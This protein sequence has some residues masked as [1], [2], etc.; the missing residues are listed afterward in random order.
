MRR[1]ALGAASALLC[2]SLQAQQPFEAIRVGG[3]TFS[4]SVRDRVENWEWFTPAGT[5]NPKYTFNGTT[6]RFGL[7][8][9]TKTLDW[10]A[11]FEAPILLS[12]P[13]NAVATGTPGQLGVGA[14]YYV[15]NGRSSNSAMLFPDKLFVRLHRFLGSEAG[16]L[17]VGRFDFQDGGEVAPKDATLAALKR[18][19]IQQRLI[20]PFSFTDVMRA[21]DGFHYVYNKP[22]VN[23]TLIGAVPTRGVFQTDGWGWLHVAFGYGSV[24]GQMHHG[25]N[26][27]DWRLFTIYYQDWRPVTKTDNRAAAAKAA[28]HAN[29]RIETFGGHFGNVTKTAAGSLDVMGEIAGQTG[30]WGVETQRAY[31]FDAEAG[32]QPNLLP[33]LKPW[34]RA[35]YYYG[36]GDSNANDNRHGTFFQLLPTA[37]PYARMPFFDMENLADRF[38]MLTLKPHKRVTFHNEIHSLRLANRNDLWYTG[39]G[40]YQPWTFGYTGRSAGGAAS[41]ANLFDVNVDV[42]VN[43]HLSVTPYLGY[44]AGKSVI[45]AVYPKGKDGHLAFLEATYRF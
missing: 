42:T 7:S 26:T 11:E 43:A 14:N 17:Q 30:S 15:A 21:F 32:F 40:A 25:A 28:D 4:G 38:A 41:L 9:N 8:Q 29:I 18:D 20:G 27:A 19:R 5:A 16:S 34:V 2:C 35:G 36:S 22:E 24:T 12:L 31:M 13:G 45:Q 1:I 37:R 23:F 39:G 33:R 3:L 6:A 10:A 44:A